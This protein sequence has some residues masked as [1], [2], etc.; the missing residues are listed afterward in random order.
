MASDL[1]KEQNFF[2]SH[3]YSTFL[4]AQHFL[5]LICFILSHKLTALKATT[6]LKIYKELEI[7]MSNQTFE[8][9]L[10]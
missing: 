5:H 10:S 2:K 7:E 8:R 1:L 6:H 4:L 9:D 3:F